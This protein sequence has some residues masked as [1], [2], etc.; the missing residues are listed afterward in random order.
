MFFKTR[1]K[2]NEW[3]N[4]RGSTELKDGGQIKFARNFLLK[5]SLEKEQP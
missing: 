3:K 5:V 1:E 2:E 4:L